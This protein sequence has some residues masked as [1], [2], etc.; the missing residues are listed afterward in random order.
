MMKKPM[1]VYKFGAPYTANYAG[2]G[3][4]TKI[5]PTYNATS[6]WYGDVFRDLY[7]MTKADAEIALANYKRE[8]ATLQKNA[9]ELFA[10]DPALFQRMEDGKCTQEDRGEKYD[11]FSSAHRTYELAKFVSKLVVMGTEHDCYVSRLNTLPS[12][13]DKNGEDMRREIADVMAH[14]GK[15]FVGWTCFGHTRAQWQ[16]E[17]V[18]AWVKKDHPE[19]TVKNRGMDCVITAKAVA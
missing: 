4:V 9:E 7:W 10:T 17:A 19:W 15:C 12:D 1:T 13:D 18:C 6:M 5:V 8:Y 11:R 16:T 2:E 14:Y 3:L